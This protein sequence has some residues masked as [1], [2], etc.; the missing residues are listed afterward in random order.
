LN[1][2]YS[3]AGTL[4]ANHLAIKRPGHMSLASRPAEVA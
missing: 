4:Q 1:R 2:F 3:I